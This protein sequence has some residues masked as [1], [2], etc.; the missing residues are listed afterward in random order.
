MIRGTQHPIN[1]RPIHQR[2]FTRRTALK[3]SMALASALALSTQA[4]CGP[5]D[6]VS[7][8]S[9]TTTASSGGDV[10]PASDIQSLVD[11]VVH[12]TVKELP[13]KRL[14][15]GLLPPTNHW[16]SG[17]V[18]GDEP[19]PVFPLPLSFGLTA[20]GFAFGLPTISATEKNI[21][22]GYKPD[23]T[24][25]TGAASAQVS[26][27]DTATVTVAGLDSSGTVLGH[28]TIAQGSPFVSYT[29][30]DAGTLTSRVDLRRDR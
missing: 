7:G 24:I 8:Q 12:R 17:L 1:Q 20:T 28:I 26:A 3:G 21:A 27:Y 10:F 15:E 11:D 30:K 13:T 19:Q 25:D 14:A 4:A 22:G 23:V 16:F 9:G 5:D 6:A 2:P 18:F 29:A